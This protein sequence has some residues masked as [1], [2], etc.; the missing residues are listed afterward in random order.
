MWPDINDKEPYSLFGSEVDGNGVAKDSDGDGVPDGL[1]KEPDTP[2]GEL[3]NYQGVTIK[4][5]EETSG[6][7]DEAVRKA[8][9]TDAAY[10]PSVFFTTNSAAT[11]STSMDKLVRVALAMQKNPDLKITLTGHADSRGSEAYN[12]KLAMRRAEAV[13]KYLV[14]NLGIAEGRITTAAKGENYSFVYYYVQHQ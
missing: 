8:I 4:Q 13:K 11:G 3:V 12:E 5:T 10:F 9:V 6:I 7:D 2:K 14:R 1:D